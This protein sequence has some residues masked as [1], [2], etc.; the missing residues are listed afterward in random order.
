ME[1][2]EQ[3]FLV[4]GRE[5]VLAVPPDPDALLAA[6]T[7]DAPYWAVVWPSAVALAEAVD[8]LE[9][10]GRSVLE[11]GCGLGL[12]SLAAARRGADVLATD[13]AAACLEYVRTSARRLGGAVETLVVDVAAPPAALLSAASFDL[14]L[15]ADVLYEGPLAIAVTALLAR[16]LG[17]GSTLLL[18][19]PWPDQ[20]P[21]LVA[22]LRRALPTLELELTEHPIAGFRAGERTSIH[23]LRGTLPP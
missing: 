17:P 4:G 19:Y 23:L 21:A 6:A 22:R 13:R 15:G 16:V 2:S 10:A 11:L 14:V 1:A 3:T 18:A 12:P 20:G 7:D 8:G 5:L 9:L